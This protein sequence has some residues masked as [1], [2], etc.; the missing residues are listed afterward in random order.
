MRPGRKRL[1]L[2]LWLV[3]STFQLETGVSSAA[4]QPSA[5]HVDESGRVP[6]PQPTEKALSYYR[7][8]NLLWFANLA[9]GLAIPVLFL[10]TGL[11]A[12][13]RNWA[14]RIGRKWFFVIGIYFLLFAAIN[15]VVDLPLS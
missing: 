15:F 11:S 6:V 4:A 2:V 7:T 14:S 9:W 1:A 5:T 12:A 13:L 8:G 10:S 3:V